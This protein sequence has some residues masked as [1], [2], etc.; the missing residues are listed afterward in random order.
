MVQINPV[1]RQTTVCQ[2]SSVHDDTGL[3]DVLHPRLPYLAYLLD[4]RLNG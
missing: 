2:I 1:N 3:Q 4:F